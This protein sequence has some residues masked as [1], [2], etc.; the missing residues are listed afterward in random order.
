MFSKIK[1]NP[2]ISALITA[3]IGLIAWFSDELKSLIKDNWI[4]IKN[5][6]LNFWTEINSSICIPIWLL[7]FSIPVIAS[8]V[9]FCK[10][11]SKNRDISL[12]NQQIND[13]KSLI[14]SGAL[15]SDALI[16]WKLVTENVLAKIFG[17]ESPNASA[18]TQKRSASTDPMN[19]SDEYY[20]KK[21]IESLKTMIS[22]LQSL[23]EI[24]RKGI[25]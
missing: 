4:T 18:L 22:T 1:K 21:R 13:A 24:R 20:E 12:L 9:P 3:T 6:L 5:Y 19:P 23:V 16:S 8:I 7:I 15:S 14:E 11:T 17:P 2:F 25:K 10:T